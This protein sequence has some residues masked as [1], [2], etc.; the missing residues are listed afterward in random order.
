MPPNRDGSLL[1]N[2]TPGKCRKCGVDVTHPRQYCDDH[3]PAPP[4]PRKA[5][6]AKRARDNVEATKV[7]AIASDVMQSAGQPKRASV[8]A[9]SKLIGK[10]LVYLT[11][12]IAMALVRGDPSLENE[13]QQEAQVDALQLHEDDAKA[14]AHPLARALHPTKLWQRYGPALIEHS[15]VLD[16]IA[17]LYDY[18]SGLARYQRRRHAGAQA[19]AN[20]PANGHIPAFVPLAADQYPQPASAYVDYQHGENWGNLPND[21]M[22]AQIRARKAAEEQE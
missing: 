12:F 8:D 6:D 16:A 1:L 10:I 21:D 7:R 19:T 11:I 2:P 13:E 5:R 17:A 20:A 18:G 3:R 9:T 22:I 14:I 15:D 4:P